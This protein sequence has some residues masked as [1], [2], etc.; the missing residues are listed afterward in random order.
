M[1]INKLFD[2]S[3][4]KQS[5]GEAL[6]LNRFKASV[7]IQGSLVACAYEQAF[8][9]KTEAP[10]EINYTVPLTESVTVTS[11]RMK[12]GEKEIEC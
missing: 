2:P 1:S 7:A 4:R 10:I 3:V 5:T 8:V 12:V 9:N 6:P 11:L